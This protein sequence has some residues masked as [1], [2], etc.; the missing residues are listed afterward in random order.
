MLYGLPLLAVGILAALPFRHSGAF[1]PSLAV[2]VP[3]GS[4]AAPAE[5]VIQPLGEVPVAWDPPGPLPTAGSEESDVQPLPLVAYEDVAAPLTLPPEIAARYS[6]AIPSTQQ[7]PQRD[8]PAVWPP[9]SDAPALDL[10]AD[11]AA[12]PGWQKGLPM[13][14]APLDVPWPSAEELASIPATS[15]DPSE[16]PD[17]TAS[18]SNAASRPPGAIPVGFPKTDRQAVSPET[19]EPTGPATATPQAPSPPKRYVIREPI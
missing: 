5:H 9:T 18:G 11:H 16:P 8:R 4:E 15:T 14:T 19:T 6:A 17:A 2:P 3:E 13:I 1:D 10:S 12:D 7:V